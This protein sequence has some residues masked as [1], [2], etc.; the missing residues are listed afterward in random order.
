VSIEAVAFVP[1][2][3]LLVSQVTGG[4][5][6]L[7]EPLRVACIDVVRRALEQNPDEVVVLAPTLST[8]PWPADAIWNFAG[9]GVARTPP[10]LRP[11]LPWALGIGAWLLDEAG[12]DGHRR[13]VGV[14][15]SPLDPGATSTLLGAAVGDPRSQVVIAVGDGS[16]CR[17]ERAPGYFDDRAER[18]DEQIADLLAGGDAAGFGQLDEVVA[19]DLLCAGLPVWRW[20]TE[21][22]AG[23]E[24]TSAELVTHIAPYGV[25]YFVALWSVRGR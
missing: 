3:P 12:W 1:A 13:Y 7:D 16:A 18:F 20:L 14:T 24:V 25:A 4:S 10:D 11:A 17:T 8:G 22:I 23:A 15:S 6:A 2:A 21:A 5:A 19:G 9:F